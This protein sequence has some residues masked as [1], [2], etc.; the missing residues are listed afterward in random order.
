MWYKKLVI[1][2]LN[3]QVLSYTND[4][5]LKVSIN[6]K[7]YEYYQVSPFLMHQIEKYLYYNNNSAAIKMLRNIKEYKRLD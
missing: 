7:I 2:S 4:G 6:G 1:S 3:I 5:L